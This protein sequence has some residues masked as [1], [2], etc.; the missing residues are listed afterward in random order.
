VFVPADA[1]VDTGVPVNVGLLMSA[2]DAIALD[3]AVSSVSISVPLT[4]LPAFP[5]GKPSLAVK[6]VAFV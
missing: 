5:V 3:T 6:L 1:V 4:I 2:L